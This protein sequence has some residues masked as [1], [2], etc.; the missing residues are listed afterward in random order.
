MRKFVIL[1]TVVIS[2]FSLFSIIRV[3]A[4][5]ELERER[6]EL[7]AELERLEMEIRQSEMDITRT[8]AE[9]ESLRYQIS[10]IENKVNNLN[11]QI[12]RNNLIIS[13]LG[14]QIGNTEDSIYRTTLKINDSREKMGD[15]LRAIHREE[16]KSLLFILLME[17][18]LSSFFTNLTLLERL[19]EETKVILDEIKAL[20]SSLQGQR[21][22]LSEEKEEVERVARIQAMQKAE[23]E[24]ARAERQRLYG[25][26]EEE[27]Q[28]Q[29]QEKRELEARAEEIRSRIFQLIGIPEV[30]MPTFGE[31]LEVARWV[32]RLTG[33]RPAFL[34]A[35]ITQESALGRNVGQCYLVDADTA[36]G[37]NIRTG[38]MVSNVMKPMHLPG[39]K[40]DTDDFLRIT[41]DLGRNPY[42]TPISCPIPSVGG[43]GGAMGPAQFIPTTW[44]GYQSRLTSILGR[45]PDPWSVNDSFLASGLLL[46]DNGASTNER[47][48]ALRY[49]AGGNWSNPS[50]SF[51]GD[52]VVR[53]TN[54]VQVFIDQGTMTPECSSLVFIPQ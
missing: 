11:Y 30:E 5:T 12:H 37:K 45:I 15:T 29:L 19:S 36:M 9:K 4:Q 28:R 26:T 17:D 1:F 42:E 31:A 40:G 16:R 21:V 48:A 32:E 25:L 34:L 24:A 46:S 22:T 33:V 18:D 3:S 10:V 6:T 54:C 44:A 13:D 27:Y 14:L 39:R 51:Y 47:T 23:E 20:R 8:E 35:I 7:E 53:R 43:Y 49:F 41:R 52:Q 2:V 38:E 50:Y